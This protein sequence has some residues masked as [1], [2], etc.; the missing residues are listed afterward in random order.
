MNQFYGEPPTLLFII[1]GSLDP[2][3]IDKEKRA[4]EAINLNTNF[5]LFGNF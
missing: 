3:I 5:L 2:V 4:N 1:R